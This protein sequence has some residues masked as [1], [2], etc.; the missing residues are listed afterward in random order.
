MAQ[1]AEWIARRTTVGKDVAMRH[2]YKVVN[3][4]RMGLKTVEAHN[5]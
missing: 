2:S 5:H 1:V 3:N 4:I